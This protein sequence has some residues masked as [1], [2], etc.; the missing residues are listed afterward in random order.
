MLWKHRSQVDSIFCRR[1]ETASCRGSPIAASRPPF[2]VVGRIH[3]QQLLDFVLESWLRH[4]WLSKNKSGRE[5]TPL[6][7]HVSRFSFSWVAFPA[8]DLVA[9]QVELAF[10]KSSFLD[11]GFN[12]AST[13]AIANVVLVLLTVNCSHVHFSTWFHDVPCDPCFVLVTAGGVTLGPE[14]EEPPQAGPGPHLETTRLVAARTLENVP[15][16]SWSSV[17]GPGWLIWGRAVGCIDVGVRGI[18]AFSHQRSD[19]RKLENQVAK[20]QN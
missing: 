16:L 15:R 8:H 3:A 20:V 14:P 5:L 19:T 12:F 13:R 6:D 4:E 18:E 2:A 9:K 17:F 1:P 11:A 7:E 10:L